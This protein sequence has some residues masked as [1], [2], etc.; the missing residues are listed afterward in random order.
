VTV[1]FGI[2]GAGVIGPTHANAIADPAV[3]ATLVAVHDAV[4]EKA[5]KLAAEHG[6]AVAGSLDELLA[7]DDVDAVA[8]CV[9]SGAHADIAVAALEAGKHVVVEKPADISLAAI[10][11]IIAARTA[12][13]RQVT[14]ISQHRFDPATRIV[15]KA[16]DDGRLGR[17][18]SGSAAINWW[19][20]QGYY[21]S[22]D[23]RGTWALDGGGA[24]MNQGIHSIDLLCWLL[25][26]PV[27]VFAFTGL[28]A[29]ERME[30]EDTAVAAVRFD[31]GALATVLGT[32]AAY[33]GMTTRIHVHGAKGSAVID[34]D[35][36][37]YFH[38]ATDEG[39]GDAY[40]ASGR[41]NQAA[42]VLA[43]AGAATGEGADAGADPGALSG[44]HRFQYR[45]FLD[46]LATGRPPLVTL[47]EGRR[48]V[49]LIL[50]IYESAR[51]GAPVRLEV[52]S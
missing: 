22:G 49:K 11:R 26:E 42:E 35:D 14:A 51:T 2:V 41:G 7:R 5:G 9:P 30:V 8:V 36:L 28:L 48:A 31:S 40:G 13:G 10:D 4:R 18:T 17:L 12:S 39:G 29:H 50:A 33:P 20:S 47:E 19:R 15:K 27:E 44:A 3:D 52:Q 46:A 38:A 6:A 34:R 37:T 16:V 43:A 45:D 23:W 32:T 25:G 21:D 1:R 24:L